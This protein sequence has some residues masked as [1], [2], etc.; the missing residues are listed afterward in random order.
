[1]KNVLFTDLSMIDWQEQKPID[2]FAPVDTVDMWGRKVIVK[3][4]E[5]AT[6]E[7]NTKAALESTRDSNGEVIGF[8]ID[9]RHHDGGD[10]AGFITDV[11]QEGGVLRFDVRWND[12]GRELIEKDLERYFSPTFDLQEKVVIGGSLTNWPASRTKDHKILLHPIELSASMQAIE[13]LEPD[14]LTFAEAVKNVLSG[15]GLMKPKPDETHIP[16]EEDVVEQVELSAEQLEAMKAELTKELISN[17]ETS[18]ELSSYLDQEANRR[19]EAALELAKRE[20]RIAEF[21]ARIVGGTEDN[22]KGLPVEQG[23]I[24][25]FMGKLPA[26]LLDEAEALLSGIVEKG[27]VDFE[28]KGH[29]R[30]MKGTAEL[31]ELMAVELQNAIEAGM[32]V[33]RFFEANAAEL[34]AMEDYDLSEFVKEEK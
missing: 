29:S 32:S 7:A 15:L 8:P 6:Y 25:E 21:S 11:N 30:E 9:Q 33:K 4:D 5:L 1:M 3:P 34:G 14:S 20:N 18:A 22:P 17:P 19:M 24:A 2:G 28:E 27:L 10:A 16:K 26:D 13:G 12:V 31:P 23:K